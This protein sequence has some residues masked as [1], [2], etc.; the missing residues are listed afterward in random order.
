MLL[1]GVTKL[2]NTKKKF[3]YYSFPWRVDGDGV[4]RKNYSKRKKGLSEFMRMEKVH[5]TR[6][7]F[8]ATM[9]AIA[10]H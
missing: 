9:E 6:A 8:R 1:Q 5:K 3:P 4:E 10:F 7:A 2:D